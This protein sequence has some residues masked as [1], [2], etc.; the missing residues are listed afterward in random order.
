MKIN[1]QAHTAQVIFSFESS[2]K[3]DIPVFLKAIENIPPGH[4]GKIKPVEHSNQRYFVSVIHIQPIRVALRNTPLKIELS[5]SYKN[6]ARNSLLTSETV[7]IEWNPSYCSFKGGPLP[8]ANLIKQTSYFT[9]SALQSHAYKN[10]KWD[11]MMHTIDFAKGRFPSGLLERFLKCL[12]GAGLTYNITRNFEFPEPYLQL[13]P[14]F[15][16]TPSEDQWKAVNALDQANNGIGKCPT[17]FGKT[18]F[19]AAALIAKKGVRSMFLANQRVLI[20]DA[21]KDFEAAF[22]NHEDLSIG[23]VGDGKY[24]LADITVAS[25]QGIVAALKPLTRSERKDLDEK[26]KIAEKNFAE[27]PDN[28]SFKSL[29]TKAKNR[30]KKAEERERRREE[31]AAFLKTVDLFVVDEAQVLG[32]DM[33]NVFL[34]ACPAPYRYTLSATVTR[35]DGGGVLIVAATGEIR[36]ESSAGDQIEKKRLSEFVAN[37]KIFDHQIPESKAQKLEISYKQAYDL[38]IV[39]NRLRNAHLVDK[40]IEW[41][42]DHSVI[43]LVTFKAHAEIIQAMFV[44]HGLDP[45]YFRYVDGETRK[46]L[47]E[48]YIQDFRDSKFPILIGTSIFDVGF[49]AKNASRIVRFNAGGSEVR[50]PQRAGRTVRMRDDGSHGESYDIRDVNVPF[51]TRQSQKRIKL[52]EE[53]FGESRVNLLPGKVYGVVDYANIRDVVSEIKEKDAMERTLEVLDEMQG[54]Q[55]HEKEVDKAVEG[56]IDGFLESVGGD[57]DLLED[58]FGPS[59]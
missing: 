33:W 19:V 8:F 7:E 17:G 28:P 49:N 27:Q 44:E 14:I 12:H 30:I 22:K 43:C 38:F 39:N 40:A 29:L 58:I 41:A 11:G 15:P 2:E 47:R 5:E 9:K 31:L 50:E 18:S 46:S 32:T 59:K 35:T 52:L 54:I 6:F 48:E 34:E 57:A 1:F 37:F 53:E 3:A 16:F 4:N 24:E 21:K 20:S 26:V 55:R 23:V 42:K 45:Q 56:Q 25:I 51:F 36:F 10:G 13:D